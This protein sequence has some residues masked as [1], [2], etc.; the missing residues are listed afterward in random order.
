M[1]RLMRRLLPYGML[2]DRQRS[3]AP[4]NDIKENGYVNRQSDR[5]DR[6]DCQR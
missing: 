4:R 6:L 1:L 5:N 3:T 2:R